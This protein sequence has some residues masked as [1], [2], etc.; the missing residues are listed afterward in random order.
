MFCPN[1]TDVYN[2]DSNIDGAYFG[3]DWVHFLMNEP[4]DDFIPKDLP[5]S[6]TPHVFGF[7]VYLP[8]NAPPTSN[9]H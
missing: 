8:S 3:P 4:H 1:C 7:N 2:Y 6:Y 5:E 9:D